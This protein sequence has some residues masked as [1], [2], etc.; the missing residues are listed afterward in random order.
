MTTP[1]R[2]ERAGID[3]LR[4]RMAEYAMAVDTLGRLGGENTEPELI[5]AVLDLVTDL[6]APAALAF[7]PCEDGSE[8]EPI[9][10]PATNTTLALA[11]AARATLVDGQQWA[12]LDAGFIVRIGTD[13]DTDATLAVMDL[14]SP[15]HRDDALN[16]ITAIS[17]VVAMA[18]HSL[19]GRQALLEHGRLAAAEEESRLAMDRSA[20][21]M[22]LVSPQG[23]FLRV[24]PALCEWLGRN[25][26]E[27]LTLTFGDVIH[28]DDV[29]VG[30]DLLFDLVTGSRS[31]FRLT[32]RYVTGDGRVIWGDVTVS[33]IRNDDGSIRN[34]I[35]QIVDVT[36]EQ[37][38]QASLQEAQRIAR[39]GSWTLDIATNHV[40]WSEEISLML[41]LDPQVP[42]PDFTEGDRLFTSDSWMRIRSAVS[43][44]RETG[45]AYELELETTRPD[46]SHGWMLVR[47]EAICDA[48]GAI[49]GLRGVALDISERKLAT[50]ELQVLSTHDPLTG[51]ANRS[52]LL[53][54]ITRAVSAGRRSGRMTAVLMMDL[55]HFKNVNDTLGHAAGDDLLVAAARRIES[56][57]PAGDLVARLGGDEF[58]V[59]MRDLADPDEAVRTADQLVTAFRSRFSIGAAEPYA[60]AS[61]GVAIATESGDA[62]DLV[63]DADT[64]MYAAK[65]EG[66]NRVSVFNE[67][68]RAI[69]N[70]RQAIENDLRRALERD[71]LALWYQPEVDLATGSVVA[72][73]ALLRWHHPDGS[74]WTADRFIDVA[75]DTGLIRDI[76]DWVLQQACAQAADWTLARPDSPLTVR[77]NLS[78]LQLT[79]A[80][81]LPTLDGALT[82]SGLDPARLCIEITET[83]LLRQT[84]TAAANLEG[85]HGRGI[86]IAIDDFGTGYASLTYLSQYPVDVLKIDRS[87]VTH[88]TT[89]EHDRRLVAGII[90]LA[91]VVNVNVTAEGVERADQAALLREMG[92]PSAQGWLYSKAV[93]AEDVTPLLDHTYH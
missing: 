20:I 16:M 21:G 69:V 71:Q 57:V 64:A 10:R 72:V 1:G 46:G 18:I 56:I 7:M 74:V 24:N 47:G 17:G 8:G 39:L 70:S 93:P 30:V 42:A 41:G 88:L 9:L 29:A 5:D 36:A 90:G 26:T 19:R 40:T 31:S 4:R 52:A 87:F 79:E 60:M 35:A 2:D 33:A 53:E 75:E 27:L 58:A 11:K 25:E 78:T 61:I 84:S 6:C 12:L 85:I 68:L 67:D 77:F 62:G 44:T 73:E 3:R 34:E 48:A 92:C 51:L 28:P 81:L 82:A 37:T 55:D 23:R 91:E 80:G 63:R 43:H 14:P 89:D 22:G 65:S 66:R 15:Q 83:A 38:L 50:E 13:T 32:E 76:G 54:E 49:V 86:G 59:V 45:A